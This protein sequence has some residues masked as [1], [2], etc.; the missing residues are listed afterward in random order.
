MAC[1]KNVK[2]VAPLSESELQCLNLPLF[3]FVK[4]NEDERFI[5]AK[6]VENGEIDTRNLIKVMKKDNGHNLVF[7]EKSASRR[8]QRILNKL[9]KTLLV[10]KRK[11]GRYFVWISTSFGKLMAK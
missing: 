11:S 5:L 1:T 3:P 2:V 6:V 8:V 7:K 10:N 9:E 4:I